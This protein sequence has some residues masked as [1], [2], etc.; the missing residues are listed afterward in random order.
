[1]AQPD[2]TPPALEPAERPV[3]LSSGLFVCGD[4]RDNGS[5]NGA[6]ASGRRAAQAVMDFISA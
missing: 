2:Q 5:L 1:H 3:E 4:H 6:M